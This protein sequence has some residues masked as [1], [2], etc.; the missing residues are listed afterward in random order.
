MKKSHECNVSWHCNLKPWSRTSV[1]WTKTKECPP[2]VESRASNSCG[3]LLRVRLC[4]VGLL[5]LLYWFSKPF[6]HSTCL[7]GWVCSWYLISKIFHALKIILWCAVV[8][9]HLMNHRQNFKK[10]SNILNLKYWSFF[11]KSTKSLPIDQYA[12]SG[13]SPLFQSLWIVSLKFLL[14][15]RRCYS[16]AM[17]TL[18][19]GCT[20]WNFDMH[21]HLGTPA[22]VS[23]PVIII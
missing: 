3:E 18:Q 1:V 4:G 2:V 21:Q 16:N 22:I 10:K 20:Y 11:T 19:W 7:A 5:V 12:R 6:I 17:I 13:S 8:S 14:K 23:F 15:N 9:W